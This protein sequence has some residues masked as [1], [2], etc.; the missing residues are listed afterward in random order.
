[1]TVNSALSILA[2]LLRDIMIGPE[3]AKQPKEPKSQPK[4]KPDIIS[5]RD[6]RGIPYKGDFP[7]PASDK[8]KGCF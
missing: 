2:G 8:T 6:E 5:R 3:P 1:M 4:G 7:N